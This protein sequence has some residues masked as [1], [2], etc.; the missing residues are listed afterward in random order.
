MDDFI[1][2]EDRVIQTI[3]RRRDRVRVLFG[4]GWSLLIVVALATYSA[5][6]LGAKQLPDF[7]F[8]FWGLITGVLLGVGLATAVANSLRSRWFDEAVSRGEI[9]AA[10]RQYL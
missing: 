7:G 6:S 2:Q 5:V 1:D 9:D 8:V 10:A 3:S 4:L